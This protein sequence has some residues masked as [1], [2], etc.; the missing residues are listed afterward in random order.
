MLASTEGGAR[1]DPLAR[2]AAIVPSATKEDF[3]AVF[4]IR[5]SAIPATAQVVGFHGVE[6]LSKPYEIGIHFSVAGT[7]FIDLRDAV[8]SKAVLAI[9]LGTAAKPFSFGGVL[10]EVRLVRAVEGN[11]L[12]FA[13]LVPH[14]WQL[15]LTKH[16]RIFTKKSLIEVI[17]A[18]LD[19][20]G[21]A[22]YELRLE[23]TFDKE[24]HITQ[25]K[26]SNLAF[27]ERW[28][29][30]EGLYYF[31]EQEDDGEKLVITNSKASHDSLRLLPV[32]YHP[33]SGGDLSAKQH[34]DDFACTYSALPASVKLT[35]YDYAKPGLET[36]GTAAVSPTGLGEVAEYG[37]R[38][39]SSQDGK[40]L[41]LIRAEEFRAHEIVYFA[42]GFA[43]SILS[44]FTFDLEEHPN[45]TFN[46]TYLTTA[47]EHHGFQLGA[48]TAWGP[49]LK[50]K[51][52]DQTY[53]IEVHAIP[54]TTQ[55][56]HGQVTPWPHVDGYENGNVDGPATS[57]Y[58]Q[59]DDQG[60]Y[61]IKFKFDEGTAKDGK[62]STFV[63]MV[64]P[65]DGAVEGQ[66]FPLRKGVEVVCDF[67]GGDP[68]RPVIL[69]SVHNAVTPSVVTSSNHTQNVIRTGSLNHIVM[70]DTAG[71]MYID[72]YCPIFT[73]T[74]F[75][76]FGEWNFNLTTQG[77]G[78]IQT[79]VNLNVDVDAELT[80]DVVGHVDIDYHATLDWTVDG[81][82]T[83]IF[84]SEL[85]WDVT[86]KV[87]WFFH[88]TFDLHVTAATT[89]KLDATL[90]VTVTGKAI[91]LFKADVDVT[92]DGNLDAHVKGNTTIVTDGNK[93]ETTHGNVTEVIDGDHDVHVK[94]KQKIT[95]DA[96]QEFLKL[97]FHKSMTVGST[98]DIFVGMKTT[99]QLAMTNDAFVGVK[100]SIT[101]AAINEINLTAKNSM[102]LGTELSFFGGVKMSIAASLQ[103]ALS[104]TNFSA[105]GINLGYSAVDIRIPSAAVIELTGGKILLNG[106]ELHI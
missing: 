66:H 59:I 67:L 17:E 101:M 83:I 78:Q 88:S 9:D 64:Q 34:F 73:S 8:Y 98:L 47:V 46:T 90:D 43:D 13:K 35:D 30:R 72:M 84:Q 58:A 85:D 44:G 76:G 21:V 69:G 48:S 81:N 37:G 1:R 60:R 82:V 20:G 22:E 91:Y 93:S 24:D 26:E 57:Q 106:V 3:M 7:E 94:G 23:G 55:Y 105:T 50:P 2:S 61:L 12:Y 79:T 103:M 11:A 14:L 4:S 62:A 15:S 51:Y 80:V 29:E 53:R 68:D 97:D 102:T 75:L 18:V 25:Y 63:R 40:R 100:N 28:M 36:T 31:F 89:V 95:I 65:H 70:E 87:D 52:P 19:E 16:S 32:R 86:A 6:G 71:A 39:F 10:R 49:L 45:P 42:T 77:S 5:S 56:R 99:L 38:F 41:A 33:L 54:A 104:A 74:L 96:P 92:I 27:I